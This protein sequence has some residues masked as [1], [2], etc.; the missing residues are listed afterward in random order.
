MKD[1]RPS[2]VNTS[3]GGF[4]AFAFVTVSTN[5][6]I[7][8][9]HSGLGD[10]SLTYHFEMNKAVTSSHSLSEDFRLCSDREPPPTNVGT[11]LLWDGSEDWLC[12][13]TLGFLRK[14]DMSFL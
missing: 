12:P 11:H 6:R 2:L 5:L 10:I 9:R 14:Q 7:H 3:E 1:L 8:V 13:L 4:S